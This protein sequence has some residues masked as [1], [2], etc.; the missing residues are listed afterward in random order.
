MLHLIQKYMNFEYTVALLYIDI[1]DL[2]YH[3]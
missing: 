1:F 2:L 3:K